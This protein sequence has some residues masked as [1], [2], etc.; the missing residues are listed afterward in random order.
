VIFD[1]GFL[2]FPKFYQVSIFCKKVVA[3]VIASK[4]KQSGALSSY[5]PRLL[6]PLFS[7]FA[8]TQSGND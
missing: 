4:A 8:M 3:H 5:S 7:G 6:H 1:F 2:I